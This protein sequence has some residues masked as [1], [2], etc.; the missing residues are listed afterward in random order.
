[1]YGFLKNLRFFEPFIVLFF[2][3][4]GVNFFQIGLLYSIREIVRNIFEIPSGI[5]AD[6]FGRRTTMI[7]SFSTYIASF[8]VFFFA[9]DF[10]FL[11]AAMSL[12]AF[13][14][15]FRTG[16][17][18]AMIFEYLR[19]NGWEDQKV[20]YYGHTRS[21]SQLGSALSALLAGSMV[22]I[23]NN[24][25]Y[26]FIYST[27]P[28]IL[29]L[30]LI[31]S[32]PK[33]LDGTT[34]NSKREK[35]I[36]ANFRDVLKEFAYTIKRPS[37]LKAMGNLSLCSGYFRAI[38]DFLQPVIKTYALSIPFLIIFNKNQR[39]AIIIGIIYFII[40]LLT[41]FTSRNAGY[42]N[43]KFKYLYKTLNVSLIIG[44]TLGAI[45]G[46]LYVRNITIFAIVTFI[47]L[48]LIENIRR[49]VGVS[50]IADKIDSKVLTSV[51][52][53]QS[54]SATLFTV[55]IAPV[56]GFFADIWGLGYALITV[57]VIL[58][59]LSPIVLLNKRFKLIANQK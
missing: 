12:Y 29:D 4:K 16:T 26:I 5:V 25:T 14:D 44:L 51:L 47:G 40:Y 13:A 20:Y 35:D 19:I 30:L 6:I 22:F 42:I 7:I 17:H 58:L 56:F 11:I 33:V 37:L 32:Y 27:I 45:S 39:S 53:V 50:Y 31:I 36:L 23:S 34:N 46:F 59:L 10:G 43:N 24:Y 28:Y 38:K 1:M 54:Q 52:S 49:P 2:L 41:S 8:M 15:S 57:S 9:N 21:Y 18:K 48:F 55:L 3:E